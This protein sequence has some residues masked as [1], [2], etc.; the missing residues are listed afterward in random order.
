M[1]FG[2]T[3]LKS[4]DITNEKWLAFIFK[5][6]PALEKQDF[7]SFEKHIVHLTAYHQKIFKDETL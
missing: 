4:L 3:H 6:P 7:H 2:I 5:Q 1:L